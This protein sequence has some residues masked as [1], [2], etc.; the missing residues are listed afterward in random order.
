MYI[1]TNIFKYT[2]KVI[3]IKV[4]DQSTECCPGCLKLTVKTINFEHT[5]HNILTID[6]VL[7]VYDNRFG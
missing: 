3:K 4:L 1:F 2:Y 6:H 5:E 7:A